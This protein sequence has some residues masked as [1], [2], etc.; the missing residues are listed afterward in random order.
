MA[1]WT[2]FSNKTRKVFCWGLKEGRRFGAAVMGLIGC[3]QQ[4]ELNRFFFIVLGSVMVQLM[5]LHK[6]FTD[7]TSIFL[8]FS[9]AT[10]SSLRIWGEKDPLEVIHN[11]SMIQYKKNGGSGFDSKHIFGMADCKVYP[12]EATWF[13]RQPGSSNPENFKEP[14]GIWQSGSGG[15][16]MEEMEVAFPRERSESV[17]KYVISFCITVCCLWYGQLVW[18]RASGNQVISRNVK[19]SKNGMERKNE[20]GAEVIFIE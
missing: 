9:A 17:L 11:Q 18:L 2:K 4:D 3:K 16:R 12:R 5:R 20:T 7:L 14:E 1:L 19:A 8:L 10:C 6:T 13:N 15:E